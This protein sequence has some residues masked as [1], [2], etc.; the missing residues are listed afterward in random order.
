M[1]IREHKNDAT[2]THNI[3]NLVWHQHSSGSAR[4]ANHACRREEEEE[5][6]K[7]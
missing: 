5:E 6:Q 2:T 7:E 4:R 1:S 3:Y